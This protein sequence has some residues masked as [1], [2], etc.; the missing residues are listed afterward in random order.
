V[1]GREELDRLKLQK[2]A[3]LLES[4]LNRATLQAEARS[5]QS[6]TAWVS[7]AT[8]VSRQLAPLLL[9]LA[10]LAGFL[11]ARGT[12]RSGSWFARAAGAVKWIIPLY[13]L[14]KSFVA[15][16]KETEEAQAP[17]D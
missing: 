2:Q 13:R 7:E 4:D 15:G 10:P 5:L 12:H 6:A 3:L 8:S 11:F 16:R 9:V 17:A 14:W 1:L